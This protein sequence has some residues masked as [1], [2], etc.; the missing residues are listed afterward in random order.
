MLEVFV[1]CLLIYNTAVYDN[2]SVDRE[3]AEHVMEMDATEVVFQHTFGDVALADL[4]CWRVAHG[5]EE[6]T[7]GGEL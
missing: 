2:P 5:T 4:F 7:G 1:S 6:H 3:W